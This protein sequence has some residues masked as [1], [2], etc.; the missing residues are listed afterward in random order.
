MTPDQIIARVKE[1]GIVE[2][3]IPYPKRP[4]QLKSAHPVHEKTHQEAVDGLWALVRTDERGE[5]LKGP[6][7]TYLT[8]WA[9]S[10]TRT[11]G[12][13]AAA[14]DRYGEVMAWMIELGKVNPRHRIAVW[15]TYGQGWS[16]TLAASKMV[17]PMWRAGLLTKRHPP[18]RNTVREWRDDG[19]LWIVQYLADGKQKAA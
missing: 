4:A 5:P 7:G 1:A 9:A 8:D 18:H 3:S 15:A 10:W 2:R 16:P 12:A 14:I 13:D 6:D 19:I 11:H 17:M